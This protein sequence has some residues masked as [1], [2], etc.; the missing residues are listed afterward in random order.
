MVLPDYS[1]AIVPEDRAGGNTTARCSGLQVIDGS[2][3]IGKMRRY[4]MLFLLTGFAGISYGVMPFHEPFVGTLRPEWYQ[5]QSTVTL[6]TPASAGISAPPAPFDGQVGKMTTTSYG[7]PSRW[8]GG[9][10]FVDWPYSGHY[11]YTLSSRFF[12]PA[13]T[14]DTI[15]SVGFKFYESYHTSSGSCSLQYTPVQKL[16]VEMSTFPVAYYGIHWHPGVH[17]PALDTPAW[18]TLKIVLYGGT[19]RAFLNG[20]FVGLADWSS[21]SNNG[22]IGGYGMKHDIENASTQMPSHSSYVDEFNATQTTTPAS[23]WQMYE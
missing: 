9:T 12:V 20:S 2:A 22:V 17:F 15:A 18:H 8:I 1:F 16:S 4:L 10:A 7:G 13:A 21:I 23:D 11:N 5:N 19:A 3:F 6:T 14:A